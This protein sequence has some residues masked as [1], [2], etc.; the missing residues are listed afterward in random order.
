MRF[1]WDAGPAQSH[2]PNA[3]HH[4][5][6]ELPHAQLLHSRPLPSLPAPS[7][8]PVSIAPPR[9][10]RFLFAPRQHTESMLSFR[11]RGRKQARC[12]ASPPPHTHTTTHPPGPSW[13]PGTPQARIRLPHGARGLFPRELPPRAGGCP[14]PALPP[15]GPKPSLHRHLSPPHPVLCPALSPKP[16]AGPFQASLPSPPQVAPGAS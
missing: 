15:E 10:G 8:S 7:T 16:A 1:C 4:Q 11:G 13:L 3:S 2:S 6:P 14:R 5:S 9:L 12:N